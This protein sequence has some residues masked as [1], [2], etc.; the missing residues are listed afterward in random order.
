MQRFRVVFHG[1]SH[2]LLVCFRLTC[3]DTYTLPHFYIQSVYQ[4]D[5]RAAHD[6]KECNTVEY[7]MAF[8]YSD[9]LYFS[10]HGLKIVIMF[11][12][13]YQLKSA[14]KRMILKLR[15]S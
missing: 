6:G 7:A 14:R 5:I 4:F 9:W 13:V 3:D 12:H 15:E 1:T 11:H 8:L 2:A 10:W